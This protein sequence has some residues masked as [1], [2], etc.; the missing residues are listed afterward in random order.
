MSWRVRQ[1]SGRFIRLEEFDEVQQRR[2][3]GRLA[4]DDSRYE[5]LP[6]VACEVLLIPRVLTEISY[7]MTEQSRD[8]IPMKRLQEPQFRDK[9]LREFL[10]AWT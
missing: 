2:Y 6:V 8:H 4:N 7:I 9:S 3:P 5:R 1:P 10:T